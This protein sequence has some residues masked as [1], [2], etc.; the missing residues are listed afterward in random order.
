M[1]KIFLILFLFI[2]IVYAVTVPSPGVFAPT[3]SAMFLYPGEKG[4]F[5]KGK[6]T[7]PETEFKKGQHW[8]S[9]KAYWDKDWLTKEYIIKKKSAKQIASENGCDENNILYFLRRCPR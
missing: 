5:I 8:R 2:P 4:R 3:P 1:K 6:R 7:S 9:K